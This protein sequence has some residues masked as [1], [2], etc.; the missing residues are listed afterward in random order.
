MLRRQPRKKSASGYAK[1]GHYLINIRPSHRYLSEARHCTGRGIGRDFN[2]LDRR[3]LFSRPEER[4]APGDYLGGWLPNGM[5][6]RSHRV[7]LKLGAI[8]RSL[9][10]AVRAQSLYSQGGA[11]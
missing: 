7:W 3:G 2:E 4:D 9:E 10:T 6:D 5:P 1:E 8:D 11:L